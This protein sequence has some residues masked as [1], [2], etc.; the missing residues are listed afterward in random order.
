MAEKIEKNGVKLLILLALIFVPF[1]ILAGYSGYFQIGFLSDDYLNLLS[2]SNSTLA[3][4]FTSDVPYYSG[5][6]YRPVWFLFIQANDMAAR[7]LNLHNDNFIVQRTANLILFFLLTSITAFTVLRTTGRLHAS[8]AA[9]CLILFFPNNLN[10]ICWTIGSIDLLAGIFIMLCVYFGSEKQGGTIPAMVFFMLG[11]LTKE[12]AIITPFI[13]VL[14]LY[15]KGGRESLT[16][17]KLK[18]AAL[19]SVLLAYAG[20]R[21]VLLGSGFTGMFT[22]FSGKGRLLVLLQ[23]VISMVIPFDYPS[24]RYNF[25]SPGIVVSVYL[26]AAF[27][28]VLTFVYML[29][30]RS[31]ASVLLLPAA[32]FLIS[33]MPNLM[34]GYFR[35]QLVL[36]PFTVTVAVLSSAAA[37]DKYV[38]RYARFVLPLAIALWVFLDLKLMNDW[39]YAYDRSR[40]ALHELLLHP[41]NELNGSVVIGLPG[42]LAQTHMMEYATGP[43]NY[44][45]H[46][47]EPVA[48]RINDIVHTSATDAVSLRAPL[49]VS[50][51]ADGKI[52]LKTTGATQYF[53]ITGSTGNEK[54]A[55]GLSVRLYEVNVF[56]KPTMAEIMPAGFNG[57]LYIFNKDRLED[58]SR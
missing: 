6:H 20:L 1:T 32:A 33:V 41:S 31:R 16:T 15:A 8:L 51:S 11:L 25:Y 47:K 48:E 10:S 42:R 45:R 58:L 40:L 12:T 24:L 19:F 3:E 28:A 22:E 57:K 23:S 44:F 56:G 39:K 30:K 52:L 26:A 2:A 54:T 29:L 18:L 13:T 5:L 38:R 50:T 14:M 55:E 17:E 49:S 27:T 34:A 4:K 36:I 53:Q 43:V 21:M 35:P 46:G 7:A 37:D 9:A